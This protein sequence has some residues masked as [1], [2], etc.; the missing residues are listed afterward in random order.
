[1]TAVEKYFFTPLYYPRTS[2]AVF[3]WWES[4]R[5]VFNLCVGGAGLFTLASITLLA[6]LPP[7]P[8][9][10][11]VP[12]EVVLVYGLM[13]LGMSLIWGVMNIVN[14]AHGAL[15]MLGAYA[16]RDGD[17][18]VEAAAA[19]AGEG[20]F[21]I[22]MGW[23]EG[24]IRAKVRTARVGDMRSLLCNTLKSIYTIIDITRCSPIHNLKKP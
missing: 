14:I 9:G 10:F 8:I 19:G 11:L 23:V 4:R 13:A 1:M 15:I 16:R 6:H 7:H 12:W 18:A 24:T 20:D 5:P 17:V 2:W 21:D 22:S 3:G